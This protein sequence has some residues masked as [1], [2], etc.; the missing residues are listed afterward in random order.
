MGKLVN[1]SLL[2]GTLINI[3]E[4][5]TSRR[6]IGERVMSRITRRSY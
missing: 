2:R 1:D 4:Y 5:F 3:V 6:D